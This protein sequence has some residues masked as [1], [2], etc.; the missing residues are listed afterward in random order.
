MD[1]EELARR[2]YQAGESKEAII[3]AFL[4]HVPDREKVEAIYQET[5]FSEGF[6]SWLRK[7]EDPVLRAAASTPK[8]AYSANTSG[9]GCRGSG[10]QI[11]HNLLPHIIGRT[12]AVVDAAQGDDGGVVPLPGDGGNHHIALAVDGVHSRLSDFPFLA[13]FHVGRA[14]LRD[15][16]AMGALP[17]AVFSDIHLGNDGDPAKVFDYVAGVAAAAEASKVPYICGSTL[18]IGGDLVLGDRLTGSAGA[19][20]LVVHKDIGRRDAAKAGDLLILTQGAGGGTITTTAI[21][22]GH[23]HVVSETL[24]VDFIELGVAILRDEKMTS[25]IHAMLDVTNGGIRG[26]A[27]EMAQ[28]TGLGITLDEKRIRDLVNPEVLKMLEEL[29]IDPLGISTDSM[30]ITASPK[31][32]DLI[33]DFIRT[34]GQKVAVVGELTEKQEGETGVV[35]IRENG[36]RKP[37]TRAFREAAY[38]PIK[39]VVGEVVEV[40]FQ[41]ME[42]ALRQA[43]EESRK[44]KDLVVGRLGEQRPR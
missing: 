3:A 19:A 22:N 40:D 27:I 14:A 21:F 7:V 28:S 2:A 31:N 16:I 17:V 23:Y 10:D 11:I 12:A 8:T 6:K 34:Q 37:I 41:E 5:V 1:L 25:N 42:A 13:G 4:E 26:D 35:L 18:R 38:T 44:K 36:S 32:A 24:D 30:L 43:A 20:G 29:D 15:V 33:L 39:K 9:L